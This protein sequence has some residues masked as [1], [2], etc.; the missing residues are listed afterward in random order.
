MRTSNNGKDH[1]SVCICTYRRNDLLDYLV[2]K[3][4]LQETAG[5]FE[6]SVVVVDND[7]AGPARAAVSALQADS[8]LPITYDVEPDK[9][10]AAARNRSVS[11]ARGNYIAFIDDDEFPPS[12]WLLKMYEAIQVFDS[13]GALGPVYPF[14]QN[15][16][17]AWLIKSGMCERPVHR[18]GTWVDWEDSRT[19]NVLI[20]RKVFDEHGLQFDPK[21][22]TSGS[23]KEYFREAMAL[24]YRFVFVKE[25][26]VY[27]VVPEARQTKEYYIRRAMVQANNERRF[28]APFLKGPAK[29][30]A[31]AKSMV[32][33][34]VYTLALPFAALRGKHALIKYQEKCVYHLSWLAAMVGINLANRRDF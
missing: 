9:C 18:T 23:D 10:I 5:K 19:G 22:R 3:L 4:W 6:L 25:A 8:P 30:M 15:T 32:A 7:A 16:P 33:V 34:G 21:Y 24:G 29:F 17:P 28:R 27:E 31:P 14:F 12:D 11:L 26:P 13:D 2:R 1:V 20:K